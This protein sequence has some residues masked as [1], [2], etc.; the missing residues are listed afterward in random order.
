MANGIVP[1]G[2]D[3]RVI[4]AE[5]EF[6]DLRWVVRFFLIFVVIGLT[7]GGL[8][9]ATLT[10]W[11]FWGVIIWALALLASGTGIGFLFGIPKVL[12]GSPAPAAPALPASS[13]GTAPRPGSPPS[14][15]QVISTYRQ[16]VN[17][18]LEE[19]SDWLTK[20]IVGVTLIQ[21]RTV[22]D[23]LW[24]LAGVISS[25]LGTGVPQG[26]GIALVLFFATSGFLFGYLVTRLYIQGALARAERGLDQEGAR[27]DRELRTMS[28]QAEREVSEAINEMPTPESAQVPPSGDIDRDLRRIADEY[29]RVNLP[30]WRERVRKK[31]ELAAQAGAHVIS[32]GISRDRLAEE[33]NEGL[34]MALAAAVQHSSQPGDAQRLLK[35]APRVARLHVMYR[36]VL[37]FSRLLDAGLVSDAEKAAINQQLNRWEARADA[38]LR[39]A[40][41]ALRRKL[42]SQD[43][44]S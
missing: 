18:N 38:S 4:P 8:Y 43:S 19:I 41:T 29:L 25:S 40:I 13:P 14:T 3:N 30:D 34:L 12:Q 21:L 31:N 44:A 1:E 5:A 27:A 16:R 7:V 9:A 36:F 15:S 37:A 28:E 42:A 2:P 10:G 35:A 32:R 24:R 17:T 11:K 23:H 22:P 26:F 20:I 33:T 6:R 39:T